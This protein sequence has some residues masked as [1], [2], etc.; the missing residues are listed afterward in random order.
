MK[1]VKIRMEQIILKTS[2]RKTLRW[3]QA[4]LMKR[5]RTTKQTRSCHRMSPMSKM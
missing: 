1:I 4:K 5:P 2:L 3:N